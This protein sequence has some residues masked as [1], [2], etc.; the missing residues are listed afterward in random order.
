MWEETGE[1]G[2]RRVRVSRSGAGGGGLLS[3]VGFARGRDVPV[4]ESCVAS[5]AVLGWCG[6]PRVAAYVVGVVL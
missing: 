6:S 5:S 2:A 1:A 3:G 4:A